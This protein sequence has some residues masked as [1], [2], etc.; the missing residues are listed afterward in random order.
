M[1]RI[2]LDYPFWDY[3]IMYDGTVLKHGEKI[4]EGY[5][6]NVKLESK[7][8]GIIFI[9]PLELILRY[10]VYREEFGL[11]NLLKGT[12]IECGKNN[13]DINLRL[14]DS[15]IINKD[16]SILGFKHIGILNY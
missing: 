1:K 16:S 2:R 13:D 12:M 8:G 6:G 11:R 3:E 4:V 7:D 5:T 9:K 10:F 14:R 15:F